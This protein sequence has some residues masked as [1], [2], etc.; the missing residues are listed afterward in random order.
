MIK[1]NVS[2]LAS[3]DIKPISYHDKSGSSGPAQ[4]SKRTRCW[5]GR[6]SLVVFSLLLVKHCILADLCTP[7]LPRTRSVTLTNFQNAGGL[8]LFLSKTMS[9]TCMISFGGRWKNTEVS[10]KLVRYSFLQEFVNCSKRCLWYWALLVKALWVLTI[11]NFLSL[12]S[13]VICLS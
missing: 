2:Q 9:P 10:L 13:E 1:I 4:S 8:P 7:S 6:L 11:S 3:L 5:I 12:G